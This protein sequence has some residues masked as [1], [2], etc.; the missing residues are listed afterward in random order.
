VLNRVCP[1]AGELPAMASAE[2][3]DNNAKDAFM[4]FSYYGKMP[5]STNGF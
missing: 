1:E 3:A 2:A 5:V 4:L